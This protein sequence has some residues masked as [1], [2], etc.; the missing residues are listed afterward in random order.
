MIIK[1]LA[2]LVLFISPTV[3][4]FPVHFDNYDSRTYKIRIVHNSGSTN[5]YTSYGPNKIAG[6]CSDPCRVE[7]EGVGTIFADNGETVV[8]K[9]G[10]MSKRR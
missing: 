5:T 2:I 10:Q 8:V 4:N 1:T 7:V 6:I 3:Q 9:G